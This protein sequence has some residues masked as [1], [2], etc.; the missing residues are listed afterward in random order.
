MSLE[1]YRGRP[2][3]IIFYLGAG[4]LHCVEQLEAFAPKTKQFADAGIA[5]LGITTDGLEKLRKSIHDYEEAGF[6]FP[7][8]SDQKLDVF[9]RYRAF[10]DAMGEPLHGPFL[11]D[12]AGLLRWCDIGHEPFMDPNFVLK[13]SLRLLAPAG[14]G[15]RPVAQTAPSP[16]S[17][18][19]RRD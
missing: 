18:G 13:E 11:I 5:L 2:V 15:L 12:G 3:V 16:P 4:C 14:S 17:S 19:G 8:V 6:P 7:L 10:D 1:H 9:K